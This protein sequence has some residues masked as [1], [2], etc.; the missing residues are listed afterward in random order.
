[1]RS[2]IVV[3]HALLE[4]YNCGCLCRAAHLAAQVV[5]AP[6]HICCVLNS[7]GS[8]L[9]CSID[10]HIYYIILYIHTCTLSLSLCLFI[11]TYGRVAVQC[12]GMHP[13]QYCSERRVL[14][15]VL[16]YNNVSSGNTKVEH[17]TLVLADC[18][19]FTSSSTSY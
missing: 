7:T 10:W 19:G 16:R 1:M 12:L 8:S 9:E 3:Q 2:R 4:Q 15:Q 13:T 5:L 6:L 11:Y 14:A 18:Y 17:N